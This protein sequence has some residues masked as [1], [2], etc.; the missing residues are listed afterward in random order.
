MMEEQLGET[1][2]DRTWFPRP[3][4]MGIFQTDPVDY[5]HSL[6]SRIKAC[7][8]CR[9]DAGANATLLW[10]SRHLSSDIG[11]KRRIRELSIQRGH[12]DVEPE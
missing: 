10:G 2:P 3:T 6:S 1:A 11:S 12:F 9:L 8:W 5:V 7:E 4:S